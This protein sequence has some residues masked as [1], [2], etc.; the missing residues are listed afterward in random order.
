MSK[1]IKLNQ[2]LDI[3][4]KNKMEKAIAWTIEN[5]DGVNIA[6]NKGKIFRHTPEHIV[7]VEHDFAP[8]IYMRRMLMQKETFVF[9]AIHKR[10]H[11]WFLLEGEITVTDESGQFKFKAPHFHISKAGTQR[12]IFANKK[13]VFQNVFKNPKDLRDLDKIEDY[14]YCTNHQEYKEYL[15]NKNK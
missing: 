5:S 2:D 12:I 15:N 6:S 14:H 7:K 8:G 4:F 3:P 13:S 1:P 11:A 9:G 10:E